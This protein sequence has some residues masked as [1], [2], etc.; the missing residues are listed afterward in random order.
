MKNQRP[1]YDP[2]QTW[3]FPTIQNKSYSNNYRKKKTTENIISL[4]IPIQR[5][6]NIKNKITKKNYETMHAKKNEAISKDKPK[7]WIDSTVYKVW[8]F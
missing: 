7:L 3:T 1:L 5:L 2:N 4:I 8:I 6:C